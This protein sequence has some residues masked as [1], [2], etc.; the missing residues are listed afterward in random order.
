MREGTTRSV[1]GEGIHPYALTLR[2]GG[3][4]LLVPIRRMTDFCAGGRAGP[5][6]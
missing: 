6:V 5:I 4:T 1:V 2:A 3:Y